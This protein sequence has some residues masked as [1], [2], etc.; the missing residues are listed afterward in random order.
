[1][2]SDYAAGNR[3]QTNHINTIEAE[4]N[5]MSALQNSVSNCSLIFYEKPETS[6]GL[7]LMKHF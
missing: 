4:K 7:A 5:F 3:A 6:L 1:M 2:F